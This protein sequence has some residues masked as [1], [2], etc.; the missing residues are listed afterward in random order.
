VQRD[1]SAV[2]LQSLVMMNDAFVAEQAGHLAQRIAS[3]Q[4]GPDDRRIESLFRLA[5]AR[6]PSDVETATCRELLHEQ[7]DVCRA[8]GLAAEAAG[9]QA[10]VQLC[11]TVLNT[12]EFLYVE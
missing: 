3:S 5:L 11:H 10:L 6:R 2:P 12:S 4:L 8:A 7:L 1:A 9:H